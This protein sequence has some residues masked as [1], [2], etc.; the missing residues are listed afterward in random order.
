M[1]P[2]SVPPPGHGLSSALLRSLKVRS[3]LG[4]GAGAGGAVD[5]GLRPDG[6]STASREPRASRRAHLARP[7]AWLGATHPGFAAAA[8]GREVGRRHRGSTPTHPNLLTPKSGSGQ[9]LP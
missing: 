1:R 7:R 2:T 9:V 4:L 8:Q 3:T 6:A 5:K